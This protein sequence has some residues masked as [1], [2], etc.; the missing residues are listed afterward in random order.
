MFSLSQLAKL[1]LVLLCFVPAVSIF[2]VSQ[3]SAAE[4]EGYGIQTPG[5][6]GGKIY[7]VTNLKDSGP[8]S[9][10]KGLSSSGPRIIRFTVGGTI[11]LK[12]R[13]RVLGSHITIDGLSAPY[14]GITLR[15]YG[16]HFSGDKGVHDIIVQG[17]R[18][19][20][21]TGLPGSEDGMTIS[22]GAYNIVVYRCSFRGATDENV[23]VIQGAHDVTFLEN[24]IADPSPS[25][26]TNMLIDKGAYHVSLIR[27]LFIGATRRNPWVTHDNDVEG[28]A[29][30]TT[31][32]VVNNLMYDVSGTGTDH[33]LVA[34]GG[35]VVNFIGNYIQTNHS[36]LGAQKRG[37][38]LC[39]ES[40][41]PEDHSFCKNGRRPAG[42]AFVAD[43][44][45]AEGWTQYL[46]QKGT[47]SA[48]L[49]VTDVVLRQ[50]C[51]A[52]QYVLV[53]AGAW[54]RDKYDTTLIAGV[55]VTGCNKEGSVTSSES[56][57][58]ISCGKKKSQRR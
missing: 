23:G 38:V 19:G 25:H 42:K 27:N 33:G 24:I 57:R 13:L 40:N 37:I 16:L 55:T 35:A 9:L 34:F 3:P 20:P 39:R 11:A 7:Y 14:P 43:N 8:G 51:D 47:T 18:V 21:T 41:T 1:W 52:A 12:G 28:S 5:G 48:P 4:R 58:T 31:A 22:H 44:I 36:D 30:R 26:D 10:R 54:P 17:I 29:P 50:A 15:N 53:H 56:T 49:P 6:A 46:N 32:D 45:S 2:N